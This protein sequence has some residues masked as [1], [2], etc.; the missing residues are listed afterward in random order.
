MKNIS[1]LGSTGSIGTQVLDVVERLPDRL[2]VVGMAA[3]RNVALLSEQVR[4]FRPQV[5]SVG[6][7]HSAELL[8][9]RL[10]DLRETEIVWGSEGLNRV[11]AI[12]QADTVVVSVAGTVGLAPT[13]EAISA[14]KDIALASK[15]VLVAAG[16]LVNRLVQDKGVRLLP[17][18]SEHSAI[19]QCLQGEDRSSIRKLMLT[20]SGGALKDCPLE[21]LQ[22]VTP[23]QALAHPNWSMGR[24]ITID[25]ATLMN[26][27]LEIIEARWL[28][29]VDPDRIEVVIHP[30]SIV[31]SMV[32][33]ADGSVM[34]QLGIPDMRLPIQYA[35]LYPER[36]DT[37][38]P[39]LNIADQGT[40]TFGRPDA[41]RYPTLELAYRAVE[42]DGT[43]PAVMNAANEVAVGLFL[44][45][46]IG[47]L[48]IERIVRRT[49]DAHVPLPEPGLRQILE[50]DSWAR[51]HATKMME[52]SI[53]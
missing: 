35:L 23:E 13:I 27:G 29:G 11:A 37:D 25:S 6:T 36:V 7:E 9:E 15:E 17:I 12:P 46:K 24:K 28:F 51:K 34:A 26:K 49:M 45:G 20:A 8:R 4:R 33:F 41:E 19:F 18:D 32:E 53:G 30:Q 22:S 2:R 50:C 10:S 31:H 21:R 1:L 52:A 47:F 39:S 48:D 42:I 43:M 3:H 14:G 16:S 38:L 44:D 5:V 40:L